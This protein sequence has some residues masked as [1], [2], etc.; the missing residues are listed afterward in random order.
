LKSFAKKGAEEFKVRQGQKNGQPKY[1][2]K[3]VWKQERAG[4][5]TAGFHGGEI[6][7]EETARGAGR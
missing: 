2:M 5:R 3:G 7:I 4:N 6:K 1:G